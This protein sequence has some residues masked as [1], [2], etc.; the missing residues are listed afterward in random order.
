MSNAKEGGME[1]E[2]TVYLDALFLMN[3]LMDIF[4]LYVTGKVIKEKLIKKK[5]LLLR[6]QVHYGQSLWYL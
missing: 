5:L 4:L 6:Q 3:W 2:Y 1:V